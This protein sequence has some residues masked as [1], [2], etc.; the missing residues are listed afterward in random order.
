MA[1]KTIDGKIELK[2]GYVLDLA[3]GKPVDFRNP[4]EKV[5]QEYE[6][7][8]YEDYEYEKAQ[9]DIEVFIQRGSRSK[10]SNDKDRADIVI[11]KTSDPSKR[12]QN[13]D[14]IGIVETKRPQREDGIRQLMSYMSATSC[15][16]G[17]W[18]NGTEIEYIYKDQNSGEIKKNFIFQ[19]PSRGL[20]VEDIGRL[21]K[22]DLKP[23]KNLKPIFRRILGVLYAN[24]NISRREKLGS[25]M[26]RLLFCKIYDEKYDTNKPPKFKIGFRDNPEDVKKNVEYLFGLVKSELV[27]DG[28]F[29]ENEK[30]LIDAKSVAYV[31]G[32]LEPF[33][34]MKTDKDIVGDAFE[35][36]A[37][38]KFV[39][40]K[41]EFFTPREVVKMC[42]RIIDPK[43]NEKIFDPACGSAGFL[44]YALEHVW[45][46]MDEDPKYKGMLDLVSL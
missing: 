12:D 46:R 23:A 25:E 13:R 43:P 19:I 7:I 5:R 30:I 20:S 33:S 27:E 22:K 8:L 31:V 45:R 41:G 44:I 28:V 39:G 37:E 38:S 32:E 2:E 6:K 16:W 26:I 42:V 24:T 10:S 29:E 35:V 34:L 11:Y 17:V 14:I 18:T 21:S 40:E 3:T 9:M 15:S 36:F 1:Q 4:E